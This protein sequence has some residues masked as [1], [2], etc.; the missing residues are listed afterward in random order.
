MRVNEVINESMDFTATKLNADKGYWEAVSGNDINLSNANMYS[1][2][3]NTLGF[4]GDEA[5]FHI[6]IDEFI[7]TAS[8]WYMR[9]SEPEPAIPSSIEHG[10]MRNR[11][12]SQTGQSRIGRGATII[13]QGKREGY[14]QEKVLS[15]IEIAKEGKEK[16]ATH[17]SAD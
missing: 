17:V 1:L 15:M 10:E 11:T 3:R 14:S 2:M 16:G 9:N 7:Q 13:N 12:D 8:K 6:P 4:K 5:G